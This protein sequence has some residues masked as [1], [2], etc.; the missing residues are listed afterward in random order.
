MKK[1]IEWLKSLDRGTVFRTILWILALANQAI[2]IIGITSYASAE[3]YQWLTAGIT[4]VTTAITWWY[5]NDFTSAAQWGTRVLEA[6]K[7]GVITEEEVKDLLGKHSD[8]EEK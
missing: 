4:F 6:L 2:A 5:N 1:F 7:D 3:W 8:P